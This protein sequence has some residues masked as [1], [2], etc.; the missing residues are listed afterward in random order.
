MAEKLDMSVREVIE[1][2]DRKFMAL[3][4]QGDCAGVAALYSSDAVMLP[5]NMDFVRGRENIQKAFE[6]F[7]AMGVAELVFQT[8]EVD[9]CGDRAIEMA[10]FN[11][12]G[13]GGQLLD[14]G[15]YI[16]VWK[17]EQG[18]WKLHRDIFNSSQPA[19]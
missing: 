2:N 6:A 3:Y 12:L 1:E 7:R 11:M 19:Q 8:L 4:K 17:H 18:E 10:S 14:A 9:H 16:V 15:K 5:A 13:D